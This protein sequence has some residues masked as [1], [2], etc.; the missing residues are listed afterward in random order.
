[1]CEIR[2][3]EVRKI[4]KGVNIKGDLNKLESKIVLFFWE[5]DVFFSRR[6]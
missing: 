1:M 6:V 5:S 2:S 4:L 3:A